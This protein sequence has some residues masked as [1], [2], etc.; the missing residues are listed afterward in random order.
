MLY[1]DLFLKF[2]SHYF[3]MLKITEIYNVF[4]QFIKLSRLRNIR[5][6]KK[7]YF[8]EIKYQINQQ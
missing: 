3:N 5:E 2:N 6:D 7:E 4:V 8:Q 1:L